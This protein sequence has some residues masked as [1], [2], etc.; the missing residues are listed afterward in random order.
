MVNSFI[1]NSRENF[2]FIKDRIEVIKKIIM[3]V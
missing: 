1:G 3:C 2:Y